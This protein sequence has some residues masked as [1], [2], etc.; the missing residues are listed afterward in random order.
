LT[1]RTFL[2]TI[3]AGASALTVITYIVVLVLSLI[4][5]LS[6]SIGRDLFHSQASVIIGGY[7]YETRIPL[8]INALAGYLGTFLVYAACFW[9]AIRNN[10]GL[11]A[12]LR[13]LTGGPRSQRVP[14]WFS[15][16]PLVSSASLLLVVVI[17]AIQ[18]SVGL[19]TGSLP[20][21]APYV[22]LYGLAYLPIIEEIAFRISV[23]G[24]LVAA[25]AV[26]YG[27]I[28][29]AIVCESPR[30]RFTRAVRLAIL[31]FLFPER[32]KAEAGL[33]RV[34]TDGLRGIHWSEWAALILTSIGFGL[35]HLLANSGWQGGKVLSASLLGLAIGA[36]YL[37]YGA[38]AS[39]LFHW[40]FDLYF[41]VTILAPAVF[42]D[43]V[44]LLVY[45]A[46]LTGFALLLSEI[47]GR[48]GFKWRAS[49]NGLYPG[50]T[51]PEIG[52]A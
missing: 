11:V 32:A 3:A 8:R 14:N 52:G 51:N 17:T 29:A 36:A 41:Y 1:F 28:S 40:Y 18:N 37:T 15:I 2:G 9:I 7:L 39:I 33:P 6:T 44:S 47:L 24:T 50:P 4:L 25:R 45:V 19:P 20:P 12:G 49:S 22:M 48:Q 46:G 30:G 23:I 5:L 26:W 34:R 38:F 13:E 43:I 35:A 27:Y 42:Q 21:V 31:G 10:G 16:M